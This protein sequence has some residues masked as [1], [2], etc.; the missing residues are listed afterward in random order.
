MFIPGHNDAIHKAW[1]YRVLTAIA[2]IPALATQL[3][4]K[5]GTCAAMRDLLNRF[6]VDLDF[7]YMGTDT[8]RAELQLLFETTIADLGLSIKQKSERGFQYFLKYT[9][10][11]GDRN[12]L[13][14]E[15]QFPPPTAN[16]Y[17]PVYFRE[18]DRTIL[19][20]T[21]DTIVANKL[22][23]PLDR[24][25]KH[26]SIAGRDI[27]DIHQFLLAGY[28]YNAGVIQERWNK[29]L[30]DFFADLIAFVE[31]NITETILNEDINVLLPAKEF[32]IIRKTLKTETLTLLCNEMNKK[33]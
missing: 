26:G 5:G 11:T 7:D 2:D 12:T 33:E 16:R 15:A 29:P 25:Q 17:E 14:V 18:I 21:I 10:H 8:E 4:F 20:Q 27:Y 31:K 30:P 23:A 32:Q 24:F 1:L 22:V 6:S 9:N 19:C 13:K 3:H 28:S